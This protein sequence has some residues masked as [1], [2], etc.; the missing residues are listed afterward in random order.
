MP[1]LHDAVY[2]LHMSISEI[3]NLIDSNDYDDTIIEAIKCDTRAGVRSLVRKLEIRKRRAEDY[4]ERY[5]ILCAL[6]D[7]IRS[8]GKKLIAGVDEAGRGPLA[9]P[10]VAASVMLPEDLYL[11]ELDD[12]NTHL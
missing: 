4:K 11:E 2:L 6:E 10:V 9:G 5:R 7:E 3:K 8:T 12:S 1:T